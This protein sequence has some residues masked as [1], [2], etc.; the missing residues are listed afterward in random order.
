LVGLMLICKPADPEAKGGIE[1][2][3]DYLERSVLP[4]RTFGYLLI[5]TPS[6]KR[7]CSSPIAAANDH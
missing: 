7:G 5:S 1:R 6:F 2:L 3:H 4:G